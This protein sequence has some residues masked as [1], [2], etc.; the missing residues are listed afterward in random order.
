MT[1]PGSALGF[2]L[3]DVWRGA[4]WR[5]GVRALVEETPLALV[6]D[7]TTYAV[8]LG[9]PADLR[10]FAMGFS[11]SEEIIERATDIDAWEIIEHSDGIEL[12]MWLVHERAHALAARRRLLAGPTG[13]GL[14]GVESLARACAPPPVVASRDL[15]MD[16][17]DVARAVA[18]LAHAQ[19]LNAAARSVHAAAL[20]D[21]RTGKLLA[22]R[23]D[24]GRHNALDKLA[25]HA[26]GADLPVRDCAVVM[27]SR[28]S[29]ELVQKCARLGAPLLIAMSAPTSLAVRT[30]D[31]AGITLIGIVRMDGFEVFTHRDRVVAPCPSQPTAHWVAT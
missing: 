19:Q 5:W 27:T 4:G 3:T 17:G 1:G 21:C 31:T 2:T 9:T 24:V 11:F 7:G 20:W 26:R 8:M 16:A 29:I 23:E 10:D 6:Y 28:V 14:C 18:A 15:T 30:A 13:C 22:A 25:G 12:R